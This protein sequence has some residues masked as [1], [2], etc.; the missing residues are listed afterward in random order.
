MKNYLVTKESLRNWV[1]AN[2]SRVIGKALV[3]IF[4]NQTEAEKANNITRLQNGIGF[5]QSDARIGSLGAKIF[6]RDGILPPWQLKHWAGINAKGEM[7]IL[8]YANQLNLIAEV[9]KDRQDQHGRMTGF[10][11]PQQ[12]PKDSGQKIIGDTLLIVMP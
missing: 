1:I 10:Q 11:P 4:K 5:T 7:R 9:K 12:F 8:K 3:A 6:I 2:P